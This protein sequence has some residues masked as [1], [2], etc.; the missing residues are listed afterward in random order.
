MIEAASRASVGPMAS[1]AGAIAEYVGLKLLP[2]SRDIIVENGGDIFIRSAIGRQLLLLAESSNF[3]SLRIAISP[4]L[5]PL[6]ICTSSGKSGHSLSLG[7]ADAVMT[8]AASPSLADAAAT[9]IAN[10]IRQSSDIKKGIK[11]AQEI[12][13][14]GVLILVEGQMGAWGQIEFLD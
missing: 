10:L 2:F 8:M 4:C 7:K 13:V 11:R 3:K 12:G 5:K 14:Y 1:V 6:G 9:A